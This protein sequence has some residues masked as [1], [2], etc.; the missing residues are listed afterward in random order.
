MLALLQFSLHTLQLF[1]CQACLFDKHETPNQP[2]SSIPRSHSDAGLLPHLQ[3][4]HQRLDLSPFQV[5]FLSRGLTGAKEFFDFLFTFAPE[6]YGAINHAQW[7]HTG[8]NLV[9]GCKLAVMGAE[10]APRS[11]HVGDLCSALNMRQ[12]LRGALHHLAR[13][14]KDRVDTEVKQHSKHFYEVWMGHIIEWFEQKYH[15]LQPEDSPASLSEVPHCGP[16][17]STFPSASSFQDS[18]LMGEEYDVTQGAPVYG[19]G[20]WPDFLWDIS[21]E[22]ILSGY[23]GFMDMSYPTLQPGNDM[24]LS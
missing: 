10:Y 21:T 11:Q 12:V 4:S 6:S 22:D 13:F 17:P 16:G 2:A 7:L 19:T 9:L 1:L 8:F 15:L 5:E 18:S 3:S 23:M 24:R 20:L 14:S